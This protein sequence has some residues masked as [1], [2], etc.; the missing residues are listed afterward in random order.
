MTRTAQFQMADG[1][2]PDPDGEARSALPSGDLRVS[3]TFGETPEAQLAIN[4]LAQLGI[5][6]GTGP[7]TF[8][9]GERV[10]REQ[11]ASFVAGPSSRLGDLVWHSAT[12]ATTRRDVHRRPA[13]K[14]SPHQVCRL[15]SSP[16]GR[17]FLTISGGRAAGRSRNVR[18]DLLR[19]C[20]AD[21][22][23]VRSWRVW[24]LRTP[25]SRPPSQPVQ[26]PSVECDFRCGRLI[27][28]DS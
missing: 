25:S 17:G 4:Q 2:L 3:S 27:E 9:P 8:S 12:A 22:H 10:T 20:P 24:H 19:W 15:Q 5:T 18:R 1:S 6:K 11:M 21:R 16:R 13:R 7:D 14:P 23:E 26:D 28:T